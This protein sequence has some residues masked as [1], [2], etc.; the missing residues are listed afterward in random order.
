MIT[1][2]P[3]SNDKLANHFTKAEAICFFDQQGG[4][5]CNFDNPATSGGC[6]AKSDL[7][8]LL[9]QQNTS[10]L[11]VKNIGQRMLQKLLDN[12]IQVFKVESGQKNLQQHISGLGVI[13]LTSIDQARPSINYDK[14]SAHGGCCSHEHGAKP[15]DKEC[16]KRAN[17][18]RCCQQH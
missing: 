2:V 15:H 5:L 13:P 17:G 14:K 11:L 4:L 3:I 10:S 7:V 8:A 16:N 18:H 1:A 9:K 12:G 6:E